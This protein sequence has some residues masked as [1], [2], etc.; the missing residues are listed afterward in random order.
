MFIARPRGMKQVLFTHG[1]FFLTSV[2]GQLLTLYRHS[3]LYAP[4]SKV[5]YNFLRRWKEISHD[6][7]RVHNDTI[8]DAMKV[9]EISNTTS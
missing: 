4:L 3:G 5:L 9:G 8:F 1:I 2:I 6:T 7:L